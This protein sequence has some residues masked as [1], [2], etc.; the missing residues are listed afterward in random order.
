MKVRYDESFSRDI[1]KL[2]NKLIIE[3]LRNVIIGL[4]EAGTL[5]EIR[6]LKKLEGYSNYYRI[7]INQY[8]L[9]MEIEHGTITILRFLH[10][11]D[12]YRNFP[13]G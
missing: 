11:K 10:R 9:G 2:R 1:K 12:I 8:R 13:P 3:Q 4:K 7:R 6:H 5:T